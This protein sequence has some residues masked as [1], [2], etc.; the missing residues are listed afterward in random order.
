MQPLKKY[1]APDSCQVKAASIPSGKP[2]QSSET[3][4]GYPSATLS[5]VS[6]QYWEPINSYLLR[7]YKYS[8]RSWDN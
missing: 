4:R 8:V 5:E 3:L 2:G 6:F 7:K 1:V